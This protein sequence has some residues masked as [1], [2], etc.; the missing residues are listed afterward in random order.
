M[1]DDVLPGFETL[2]PLDPPE[3]LSPDRR[4][5]QRQAEA[6]ATGVHP[7]SSPLQKYLPL[8]TDSE[9]KCGNCAFRKLL[10]GY[11]RTYPKCVV[12][13]PTRISHGAATDIRAWWPACPDHEWGDP[14][15]SPDAARSGPAR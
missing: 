14:K 12:D 3:P 13:G 7:L 1:T 6:I 5:T 8:H 9:R 2:V 4:R 10:G 11:L 15:L